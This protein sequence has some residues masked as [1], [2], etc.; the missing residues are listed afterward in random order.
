[1]RTISIKFFYS[2]PLLVLISGCIP[3]I[4]VAPPK[5]PVTINMNV[6]VDHEINIKADPK[7][8]ALLE[9]QSQLLKPASQAADKAGTAD[10]ANTTDQ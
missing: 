5:E 3:R 4:E 2:V 8:Q 10:K 1:M 7:V 6:K 9:R